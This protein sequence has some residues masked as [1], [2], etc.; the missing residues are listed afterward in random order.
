[1]S[2]LGKISLLL[3]V[4]TGAVTGLLFAPTRGK[5]LRERIT[6]ERSEGG[7]GHKAIAEDLAK[8]ADDVAKMAKETAQSEEAKRFF[9][10]ANKSVGEWTQGNVDLEEWTKTAH[11]KIDLLKGMI[12]KYADAKRGSLEGAK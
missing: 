5:S 7:L 10:K 4:V 11:K 6:K 3:G 8:M 12:N 2:R 1:M 9:Q